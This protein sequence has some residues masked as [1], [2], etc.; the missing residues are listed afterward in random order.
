M[1]QEITVISRPV[2]ITLHKISA[3]NDRYQYE[4]RVDGNVA[5]MVF[6]RVK[7]PSVEDIRIEP[8]FRKKNIARMVYIFLENEFFS[9]HADV[10]EIEAYASAIGFWT[11][12]GYEMDRIEEYNTYGRPYLVL[13]TKHI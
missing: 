8:K 1:K 10:M 7:D 6:F 3:R 13:M 9:K 2:S 4:I 5:G 12:V 11:S